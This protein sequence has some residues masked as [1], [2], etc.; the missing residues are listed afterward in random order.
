MTTATR[1]FDIIKYAWEQNGDG[2]YTIGEADMDITK[3]P[4]GFRFKFEGIEGD[5][6]SGTIYSYPKAKAKIGTLDAR[7]PVVDETLAKRIA[8]KM[9][10]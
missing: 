5:A 8:T 10:I 3:T 4:G 1:V 6:K 2:N 9:G 7:F